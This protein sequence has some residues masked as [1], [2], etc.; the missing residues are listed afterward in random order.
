MFFSSQSAFASSL[1][2]YFP[3]IIELM[4]DA[5]LN[6]NFTQ[7][8]FDK[9]KDKVLTGLK[10]EEKDVK[11]IASRVQ[12]A[13][14]YGTDHPFGEFTSEETVNNVSLADV[15]NF[16]SRYF[17]PA[18]A[19]LVVIGDVN[20]DET[21]KLVEKYFTPWT[22]A[23]PPSFQYSSPSDALYTQVNFIDVPNAVQSEISVQN[24][25]NLKMKDSDYLSALLA[26]EI[27]GG[28][29]AGRLYLNLR[30]DKGYTYGSYSGIGNDKNGPSR[31]RATASVRNVVTDSMALE[32]PETIARYALNIE[33]EN[34]DKDF[35]KNYLERIN[36]ISIEDVQNA[37]QKYMSTENARI[38]VTG[39]G[40]EV[41]E[42]LEKVNFN[43]K[44]IPFKYYD[45]FAV[46]TEKPNYD[47]AVPEGV[48]VNSIISKYIDAIGGK[49]KLEGV[50]SYKMVAEAEMQGMKL[51]LEMKKT[52][53][54]QFMQDVKVMGNSMSKQVVNG[55]S[56]YL[57]MQGQ[58]KDMD[59]NELKKV[60]AETA[61]FPGIEDVNGQKAY[62]V[63]VSDEK[64]AFFD[65]ETG[66][67]IQEVTKAEMMG[68]EVIS[69]INYSDYRAVEGILFPYGISQSMGPQVLDF[70]VSE[71][72][73]NEGVTDA[74]FE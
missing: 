36:A 38:V 43:G 62:K 21:K 30:E 48:S 42:N 65:T 12:R 19:Y 59:E 11:T 69:T 17:V 66:L 4:A 63:N 55:N 52:S 16:Y 73:I 60:S 23:T 2:K 22:K 13:L 37:A 56:G 20:L 24:L 39:K 64:S 15:A 28:G 72:K 25:V 49:S 50:N 54:N 70:V 45:K 10:T 74:D 18:N 51:N 47:S 41:L 26:N 14:A 46:A 32:D 53:K 1:S 31:F 58:R 33:T 71:I 3:R 6:P 5:C 40:S 9:E 68:Q 8:E 61:P 27:L 67:K 35:Y 29:G 57:M 34:L 44:A 7:E